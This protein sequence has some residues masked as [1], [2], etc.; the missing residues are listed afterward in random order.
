MAAQKGKICVILIFVKNSICGRRIG[1]LVAVSHNMLILPERE[2]DRDGRFCSSWIRREGRTV[3][4]IEKATALRGSR[5][6]ATDSHPGP[7]HGARRDSKNK[8]RQASARQI[9]NGHMSLKRAI[10]V[11]GRHSFWGRQGRR[12]SRVFAI[13]AR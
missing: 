13:N 7:H 8:T 10:D 3:I 4:E 12:A 9:T 11:S 6:G 5:S 1:F 2:I